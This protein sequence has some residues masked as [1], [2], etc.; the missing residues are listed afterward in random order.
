MRG[1]RLFSNPVTFGEFKSIANRY[2]P[3]DCFNK[4]FDYSFSIKHSENVR[5]V[6]ICPYPGTINHGNV[7]DYAGM[8]NVTD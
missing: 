6:Y 2:K 7:T 5:Q 4:L 8:Y 3:T 1:S